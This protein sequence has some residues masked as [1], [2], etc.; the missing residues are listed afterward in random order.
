MLSRLGGD[1]LLPSKKDLPKRAEK[2]SPTS[3]SD[4]E[5][6]SETALWQ[7]SCVRSWMVT[8]PQPKT[9]RKP[10]QTLMQHQGPNVHL[11]RRNHR[12]L[13]SVK[14]N[15]KVVSLCFP[16]KRGTN[17]NSCTKKSMV[18]RVFVGVLPFIKQWP[19]NIK[20]VRIY[21]P[22]NETCGQCF[23][24]EE[25]QKDAQ[26]KR[27]ESDVNC[28]WK[29]L[30]VSSRAQRR[31]FL[32]ENSEESN[33]TLSKRYSCITICRSWF[34]VCALAAFL[35]SMPGHIMKS[36][37]MTH[38]AQFSDACVFWWACNFC[39]NACCPVSFS[40]SVASWHPSVWKPKQDLNMDKTYNYKFG[41]M[42]QMSCCS[43]PNHSWN[44]TCRE[45]IS[46]RTYR[47]QCHA[48]KKKV[49]S[50]KY[51][52]HS[53]Q[54]NVLSHNSRHG[55]PPNLTTFSTPHT[56]IFPSLEVGHGNKN[57]D[58]WTKQDRH[59]LKSTVTCIRYK[60]SENLHWN[61]DETIKL[62]LT[63]FFLFRFF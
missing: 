40:S 14:A 2:S 41:I 30:T 63:P 32:K 13:R 36:V 9:H 20:W 3:L 51:T 53:M 47:A 56:F 46:A 18:S 35:F 58:K 29:N 50:T 11:P 44:Q 25:K 62:R 4:V 15:G 26:N 34:Y 21:W 38:H 8:V 7:L 43:P 5:V 28:R 59:N 10:T 12:S 6:V 61:L 48:G 54:L 24:D 1:V 17:R 22:V 49:I 23:S 60:V 42:H 55:P 19:W 33:G 37:V 45:K 57:L 52:L 39:W 27:N 16:V 31:Y